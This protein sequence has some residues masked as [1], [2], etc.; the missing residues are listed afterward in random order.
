MASSKIYAILLSTWLCTYEANNLQ[1][2]TCMR[3]VTKIL[4][5]N[6]RIIYKNIFSISRALPRDD[7]DDKESKGLSPKKYRS[8]R[9][10]PHQSI[11]AKLQETKALERSPH[12]TSPQKQRKKLQGHSFDEGA[13]HDGKRL[14]IILTNDRKRP[15]FGKFS[16]YIFS[17][18]LEFQN[19]S[20]NIRR[21]QKVNISRFKC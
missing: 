19:Q 3:L 12:K 14:N 9:S 17:I 10:A 20:K 5:Y 8:F 16:H 15:N 4:S 1:K 7:K 21:I 6:C 11:H 2:F 13:I 18:S